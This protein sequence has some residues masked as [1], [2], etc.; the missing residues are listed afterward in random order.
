MMTESVDQSFQK[1]PRDPEGLKGGMS[2]LPHEKTS[3]DSSPGRTEVNSRKLV[4][5]RQG[6]AASQLQ[7]RDSDGLNRRQPDAME[8]K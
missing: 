1:L 3:P 7:E 6:T 2:P 4:Y 8:K 5:L